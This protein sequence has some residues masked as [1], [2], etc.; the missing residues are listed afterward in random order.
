M[1]TLKVPPGSQPNT[2]FKLK[3]KGVKRVD[4]PKIRGNQ[5]VNLVVSIPQNLT[6]KQKDLI[7]EFSN[8]TG[9]SNDQSKSQKDDTHNDDKF[10]IKNAW[11]RLS[12]FLGKKS[13]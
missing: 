2:K 5:I 6:Q 9:S 13:N 1:V 12:E 7:T 3:G 11:S 10:S 8:A 4:N